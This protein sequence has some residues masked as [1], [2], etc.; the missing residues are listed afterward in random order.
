MRSGM[1]AIPFE[2]GPRATLRL[3]RHDGDVRAGSESMRALTWA[4]SG[5]L[6]VL[7]SMREGVDIAAC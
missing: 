3:V 7:A 5:A 4:T 1:V 6:G 2:L